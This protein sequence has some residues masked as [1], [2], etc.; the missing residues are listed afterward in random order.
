MA[1]CSIVGFQCPADDAPAQRCAPKQPQRSLLSEL[2]KDQQSSPCLLGQNSD[3]TSE[4]YDAHN[5]DYEQ[6]D[7][8]DE[9]HSDDDAMETG[10]DCSS[11]DHLGTSEPI[12]IPCPR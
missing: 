1:A 9:D 11:R 2:L 7:S 8:S 6:D 5:S 12:P 10:S 4:E 3:S